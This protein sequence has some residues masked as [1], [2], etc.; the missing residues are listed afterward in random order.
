MIKE[1]NPPSSIGKVE[2]TLVLKSKNPQWQ[3]K[4]QGSLKEG[5]YQQA[6]H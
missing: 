3:N 2:G 5:Y 4:Y 6:K 1:A